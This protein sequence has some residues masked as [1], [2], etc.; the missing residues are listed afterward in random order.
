MTLKEAEASARHY[1]RTEGLHM[2]WGWQTNDVT[3]K[4]EAGYCPKVIAGPAFV[5]TIKGEIRP[6]NAEE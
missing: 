5:H 6:K 1:A 4:R 2:V 3:G